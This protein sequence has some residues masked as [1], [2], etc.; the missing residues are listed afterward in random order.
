MK[1]YKKEIAVL[2]EKNVQ[3]AINESTASF[4]VDMETL[5]QE[6]VRLNR[7]AQDSKTDFMK[8]IIAFVLAFLIGFVL[9][10]L[11]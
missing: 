6:N 10:K 1:S 4:K 5:K 11:V 7:Q 3:S 9:A 8:I 2:H